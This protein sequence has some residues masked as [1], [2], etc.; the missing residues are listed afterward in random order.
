MHLKQWN[1]VDILAT[2]KRI[3]VAIVRTVLHVQEVFKMSEHGPRMCAVCAYYFPICSRGRRS[4][5]YF[6]L[7]LWNIRSSTRQ[8]ET[9]PETDGH[10]GWVEGAGNAD[11]LVGVDGGRQSVLEGSSTGH[12]LALPRRDQRDEAERKAL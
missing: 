8:L 1:I 9:Q 7:N 12:H 3:H 6:K 4:L 10:S 5:H 11:L 2:K